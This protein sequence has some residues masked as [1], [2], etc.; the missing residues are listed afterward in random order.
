MILLSG[1]PL[2]GSPTS[3]LLSCTLSPNTRAVQADMNLRFEDQSRFKM[4]GLISPRDC[5]SA[6]RLDAIGGLAAPLPNLWSK[7]D[8]AD[9]VNLSG[10][11][12]TTANS[13]PVQ[14]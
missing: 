12:D 2:R 11:S 5:A 13:R 4:P 14:G 10:Q 6:Q 3:V 8:L 1:S 9:L 7:P